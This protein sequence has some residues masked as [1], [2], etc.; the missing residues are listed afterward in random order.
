[1]KDFS[2]QFLEVKDHFKTQEEF[3]LL[4]DPES[5]LLKT[6]P[7]PDTEDLARYYESTDYL[8]HNDDT[9]GAFAKAYQIVKRRNLKTKSDLI[10]KYADSSKVLDIG[11]GTGDLVGQLSKQG[12]SAFGTEPNQGARE[13]AAQKNIYLEKNSSDFKDA[14]FSV[15]TMWHVLEHVPDIENQKTEIGRLLTSNGT[16]ILALPN[17]ESFD[18]KFFGPFWAGYDVPRHLYHFNKQAILDVFGKEYNIIAIKNQW[19]DSFYVSI[20][21]AKYKKWYLPMISGAFMGMMSNLFSLN[22]KNTS[23]LVYILQKRK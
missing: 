15:I 8:S 2:Q 16:L 22:S 19:W 14:D 7:Q 20:L 12:I 18:A 17:Y 5:G 11:A 21:S 4:K 23:S 10:S 3:L 9:K 1:M 6:F 13:L